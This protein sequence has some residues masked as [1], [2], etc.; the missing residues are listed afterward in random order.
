MNTRWDAQVALVRLTGQN[1][2]T[3]AQAW[4]EWYM[5]NR[6]KLGADLPAFDA[7][8]VDWTFGSTNPE[9]Q[10]WSDPAVQE[11]SDARQFGHSEPVQ[12]AVPSSVPF[13]TPEGGY[14]HLVLFTGKG[15]FEPRTPQGLLNRLNTV[16][17]NT[18]VA[19][20][21]FRTWAENNRL[22]GG[23]CTDDVAGLRN[24]IELIPDLELLSAEPLTE[25]SFQQHAEKQ[26]ESLPEAEW[27]AMKDFENDT[28]P[29]PSGLLQTIQEKRRAIQ[30]AEYTVQYIGMGGFATQ[31]RMPRWGTSQATFRFQGKNQW[32]A[33]IS[34]LLAIEAYQTG[35]DGKT[36]WSF[37]IPHQGGGVG[38]TSY[39]TRNL[40]D[41]KEISLSFLDP[42]GFLDEP[43]E[44]LEETM[45]EQGFRYFGEEE[46]EGV[47]RHLFGRAIQHTP[48]GTY[49]TLIEITLNSETLLP[50]TVR[51]QIDGTFNSGDE[52]QPMS[53]KEMRIFDFVSTNKE[54]PDTAFLPDRTGG[55]VPVMKEQPGEGYDTFFV[56]INDGSGG[57]ISVRSKGQRG[58]QAAWS[59]GL[60]Y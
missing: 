52:P 49:T 5:A 60:D 13:K 41:I 44:S 10:R 14:T 39:E 26:Q 32:F 8:R 38:P 15:D 17:L 45:E 7:T 30:S 58:P 43:V 11:E 37:V 25:S 6:D 48:D 33:D 21:F 51:N 40:V 53:L 20:G 9:M 59:G 29:L 1:F 34:E 18:R 23:I 4:G 47:K 28:Q 50:D 19:T 42:F 24:V 55:A 35:C 57:R 16:L 3:D 12:S 36:E 22:I 27:R 2:G 31:N 56:H 46:I 54:L